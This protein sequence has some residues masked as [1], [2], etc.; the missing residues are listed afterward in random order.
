MFRNTKQKACIFK[1]VQELC[2][3][4]AQ[5]IYLS[6]KNMC[7]TISMGTVYRILGSLVKNN[8]LTQIQVP[9][10]ADCYD[11]NNTKHYHLI[12]KKCGKICDIDTPY[13]PQLNQ[14]STN[15]YLIEAHTILFSGIC[16]HCHQPK[17]GE[18]L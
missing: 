11:W 13:I 5:D 10:H 15:G 7:P 3:P 18:K 17:E 9:G 16:P 12:C 14:V 8:Q 2:H 6:V 4:T 1:T